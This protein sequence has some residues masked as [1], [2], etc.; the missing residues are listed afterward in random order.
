MIFVVFISYIVF[1]NKKPLCCA[2]LI[3]MSHKDDVLNVVYE[4]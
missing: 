1:H 2:L 4:T 3:F